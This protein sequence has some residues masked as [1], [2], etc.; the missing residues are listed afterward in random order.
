MES[1]FIALAA[2]G[3]ETE[4]LKNLLF[5]FDLWPQLMPSISLYC[6][7]EATLSRAYNLE[8]CIGINI[9]TEWITKTGH[10]LQP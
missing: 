10:L 7:S 6:D 4:W 2:A 1:E 9:K 8:F 5:N 3:K